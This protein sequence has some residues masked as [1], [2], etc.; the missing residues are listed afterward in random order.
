M[1]SSVWELLQMITKVVHNLYKEFEKHAH[2][3]PVS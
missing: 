1:S 3:N 2:D